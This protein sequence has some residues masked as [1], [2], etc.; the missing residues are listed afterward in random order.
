MFRTLK[1][2]FSNLRFLVGANTLKLPVP[3]NPPLVFILSVP[4]GFENLPLIPSSANS[5]NMND[6]NNVAPQRARA[7]R[8]MNLLFADWV[9]DHHNVLLSEMLLTSDIR[10]IHM[11]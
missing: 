2:P 11:H 10:T 9:N 4:L 1:P 6:M 3:T 8:E 7:A 5:R